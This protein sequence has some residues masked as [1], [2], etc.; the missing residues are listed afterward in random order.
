MAT[1]RKWHHYQD[2][3][4]ILDTLKE[5]LLNSLFNCELDQVHLFSIIIECFWKTVN[6]IS[7]EYDFPAT[8]SMVEKLH[9]LR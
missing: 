3:L 9:F 7:K 6:D 4:D 1:Q 8:S 2:F 5:N